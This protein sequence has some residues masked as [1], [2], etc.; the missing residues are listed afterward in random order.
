MPCSGRAQTS[1]FRAARRLEEA[2][3]G[4]G[5]RDPSRLEELRR[6]VADSGHGGG[7]TSLS[8]SSSTGGGPQ[9]P[10]FSSFIEAGAV[11]PFSRFFLAALDSYGILLPQLTPAAVA[12]MSSF[13]HLYENYVGVM[14]SQ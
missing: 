6:R 12:V 1:C 9:M 14:P 3:F 5:L 10:I 4:V 13:Q 11:P 8:S 7:V 2:F